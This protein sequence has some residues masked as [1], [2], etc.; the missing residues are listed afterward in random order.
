MKIF[1][2]WQHWFPVAPNREVVAQRLSRFY[3]ESH[4]YHDMTS[5]G[6]KTKDPQVALLSSLLVPGGHYAEVGCGGGVVCRLVA[7]VANV[8]GMDIS[9]IALCS[10]RER[11]AGAKGEVRFIQSSADSLPLPD[12]AFD[13]VYSFEVI[14]HVWEP[15]G[16]LREMIRV[17]KPGGY[18]LLS[19]PNRFSLDLHLNKRMAVRFIDLVLA[20]MRRIYDL[21]SG[22]T[23]CHVP[24]DFNHG[25]YPDC[26]MITAVVPPNIVNFM[27]KRGCE[28]VFWDTTYMCALRPGSKTTLA[29]QQYA[30]CPF[31][32]NFGDHL[33]LCVRKK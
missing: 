11:C 7:D 16:M 23:Y 15:E 10:A 9:E 27:E 21:A 6:D 17:V 2:Q 14:E 12:G 1:D 24:P 32:R 28:V 26:D 25:V 19:T 13:G 18:I 8:V 31:L 33:L 30:G 4:E 22:K 3:A 29:Y 5:G 20:M